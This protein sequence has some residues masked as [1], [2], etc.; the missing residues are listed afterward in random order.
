MFQIKMNYIL[1][2][3]DTINN[4]LEFQMKNA[5][6]ETFDR[7]YKAYNTCL[8]NGKILEFS[9]VMTEVREI[10]SVLSGR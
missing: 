1:P 3:G 7:W 8:D 10:Y 6:E 9:M 5:A 2:N 4:V